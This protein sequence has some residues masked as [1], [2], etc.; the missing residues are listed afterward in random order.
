M[1]TVRSRHDRRNRCHVHG[2]IARH[3]E[4]LKIRCL[5]GGIPAYAQLSLP[6]L[7]MRVRIQYLLT[8]SFHIHGIVDLRTLIPFVCEGAVLPCDVGEGLT[9]AGCVRRR[10]CRMH[11]VFFWINEILSLGT[12]IRGHVYNSTFSTAGCGIISAPGEV[13]CLSPLTPAAASVAP[14][15]E[16]E[17]PAAS[18]SATHVS[19]GERVPS[20]PEVAT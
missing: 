14:S 8:F 9:S 17:P 10:C 16:A 3:Q 12:C 13:T 11:T 5:Q 15:Y 18:R 6:V 19:A 20:Q 2:G 7:G 1:L 4:M